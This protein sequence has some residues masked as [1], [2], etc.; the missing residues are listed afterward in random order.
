LEMER[1][2][3]QKRVHTYLRRGRNVRDQTMAL[4]APMTSSLGGTGPD[5]GQIPLRTY[6]GDVPISE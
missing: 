2:K 1:E 4:I 6:R 3:R 5:V